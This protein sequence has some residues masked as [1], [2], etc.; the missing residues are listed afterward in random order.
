VTGARL[1]GAT[2]LLGVVGD[3]IAQVRS[4]AVWTALFGRNGVNAV[5]VPL[6]VHAASLPTIFAGISRLANLVGLIITIPHKPAVLE[7]LDDASDRAR[8]VG[9]VN[10]VRIDPTGR[11]YGDM[12]DGEGCVAGLRAGGQVI[13]GRRALIV[14]CGGVGSAIAFAIA[15]AGAREVAVSDVA[16]D[17]AHQLTARLDTA[18]FAA[19]VHAPTADGFDLIVNASPA[20][21]YPG[22][23]LPV[24]CA[25]LD[26]AAVVADVVVHA[27]L[28]P[29]LTIARARG[30]FVQPGALMSD[31][32]V[33]FMAP[34]FGLPA[35]DCSPAAILHALTATDQVR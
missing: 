8:Q 15:N 21:M 26:P 30:C 35:G 9:A 27:E 5:C 17:R 7:L 31:H 6:H 19:R 13:A 33:A 14:G 25:R 22:D 34:F 3:P 23:P 4:P 24:D 20:G 28:T 16:P 10:A 18:G 11:T 29:L 12:F 32:Q 2:R 1:D